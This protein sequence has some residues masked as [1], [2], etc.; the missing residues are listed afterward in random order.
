MYSLEDL[1]A[2]VATHGWIVMKVANDKGPEFAYSIGLF[3][4]FGH[5]EVIMFGLA[6][7]VMHHL[8][9]DAGALIRG[10]KVFSAGELSSEFLEGF[11]VT[12]R[13]V[14]E[15]QYDGHFG[16]ATSFYREL[17]F[18][19]LQIVYPDRL[20]RWPWHDGVDAGFLER[21]PVLSDISEPPWASRPAI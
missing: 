18:P 2:D 1:A 11:D 6:P 12:F 19:A 21:Q 5:P 10:G 20:A 15:F 8:I 17:K 16:W 7:E 13:R 3:H 14:P 4:T 9:N